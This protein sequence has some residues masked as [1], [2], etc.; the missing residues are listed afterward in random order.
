M[1]VSERRKK[2][3]GKEENEKQVV[4]L[5]TLREGSSLRMKFLRSAVESKS[6]KKKKER[7]EVSSDDHPAVG[8]RPGSHCSGDEARNA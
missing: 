8:R 2:R 5:L 7:G 4:S 1:D 6:K 3:R